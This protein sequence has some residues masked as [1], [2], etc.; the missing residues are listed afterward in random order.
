[1]FCK[2]LE[3]RGIDVKLDMR[4]RF[5]RILCLGMSEAKKI[6]CEVLEPGFTVNLVG[7][8]AKSTKPV[9]LFELKD[10]HRQKSKGS[11][12]NSQNIEL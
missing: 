3:D 7:F 9:S 6:N 11:L 10:T 8:Q 5:C 12:L 4:S 2:D 1:M